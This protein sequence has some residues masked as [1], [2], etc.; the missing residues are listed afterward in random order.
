MSDTAGG[1][2]EFGPFR[3][4]AGQRLL[5]REGEMVPLAPKA[6]EMLHALLERRGRVVGKGEL[7]KLVWPDTV[8]EEV[9]L[10]RNVSLLRKALGDGAETGNYI[11]TIPKRGYRFTAKVAETSDA[12]QS[13]AFRPG[14]RLR[15]WVVLAIVLVG[16]A[17]IVYW[18]FYA[19]SRYLPEGS[20]SL[21]VAPFETLGPDT[22]G[23]AFS[24]GFTEVLAAEL[25]KLKDVHVISPG[26]VRRYRR[27]RIPAPMM[28]RLLGVQ[29]I[30]EGTVQRS[31][32]RLT[33]TARLTD[34]HSGKLIWAENFDVAAAD[35]AQGQMTIARAV[36]TQARARL[37]AR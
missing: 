36:A 12:A 15:S 20:A 14:R 7:M 26:T 30:V 25:S 24:E 19:P 16:L 35:S 6:L 13:S 33:V 34:V 31:G 27:F 23:G 17:G 8:V 4:D 37:A 10:A 21:A 32:D 29:V 1:I 2:Y 3:Y 28:A 11:E 22:E 18:Q 9:G 5:F